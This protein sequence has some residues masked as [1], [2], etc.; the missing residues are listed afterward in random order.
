VWQ[1]S[2]GT[3]FSYAAQYL[4]HYSDSSGRAGMVTS[5]PVR[6]MLDLPATHP[7][8]HLEDDD[9]IEAEFSALS[10]RIFRLPL[11]LDRL[12]GHLNLRV[13]QPD[14]ELPRIN[15]ITKAYREVLAKLPLLSSQG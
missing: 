2:A 9:A 4:L 6:E 1:D 10:D 15:N 8:Y 7:L 11:T 13:G 14:V 5:V 3:S 12:S